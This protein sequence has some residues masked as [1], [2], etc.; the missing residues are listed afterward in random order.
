MIG[1]S[2]LL[3]FVNYLLLCIFGY[4]VVDDPRDIKPNILEN[5]GALAKQIHQP[6]KMAGRICG[7]LL[8]DEFLGGE[9]LGGEF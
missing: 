3:I 7:V 5:L 8:Q 4:C 2:N 1:G 6:K 9:F